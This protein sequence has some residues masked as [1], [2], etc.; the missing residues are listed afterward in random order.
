MTLHNSPLTGILTKHRPLASIPG[1]QV[2]FNQRHDWNVFVFM[3]LLLSYMVR[4]HDERSSLMHWQ[5]QC[6]PPCLTVHPICVLPLKRLRDMCVSGGGNSFIYVDDSS[7]SPALVFQIQQQL[8]EPC[9]AGV[10]HER[11]SHNDLDS[12][13][14]A[15]LSF[16]TSPF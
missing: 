7:L 14:S 4:P 11:W 10:R 9:V 2:A 3:P 8:K 15:L 1:L 13:M 6:R 5:V 16:A 12:I